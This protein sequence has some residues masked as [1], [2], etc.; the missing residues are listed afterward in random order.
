MKKIY[1]AIVILVLLGL[2]LYLMEGDEKDD[3]KDDKTATTT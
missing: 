3:K 1:V 2:S